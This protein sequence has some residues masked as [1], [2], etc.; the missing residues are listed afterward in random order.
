MQ[1]VVLEGYAQAG[2]VGASRTDTFIDGRITVGHRLQA[3]AGEK[4]LMV[5]I[6]LSGGPQPSLSRLDI[7]PQISARLPIGNGHARLA[8]G[9]RHRIAGRARPPPELAVILS[10]AFLF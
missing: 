3:V 9:W 1:G 7:G 8:L 6:A 10:Y 4:D 2:V 5:G